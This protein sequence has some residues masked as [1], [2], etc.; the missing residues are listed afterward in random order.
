MVLR[1]IDIFVTLCNN[2]KRK[3]NH[4]PLHLMLGLLLVDEIQ[5]NPERVIN[6]FDP[7]WIIPSLVLLLNG[8]SLDQR[9]T[10]YVQDCCDTDEDRLRGTDMITCLED[11]QSQRVVRVRWDLTEKSLAS[12]NYT[13]PLDSCPVQ[14]LDTHNQPVGTVYFGLRRANGR[15]AERRFDQQV[16]VVSVRADD[17]LDITR[18]ISDLRVVQRALASKWLR[19]MVGLSGQGVQATTAQAK[20]WGWI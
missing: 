14:L 9:Y 5:L 11:T 4:K 2:I 20:A 3:V 1:I 15:G 6:M 18:S 12:K 17:S 16:V 7:T 10:V 8:R 13:A 19:I